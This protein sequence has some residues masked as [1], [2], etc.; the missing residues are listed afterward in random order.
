MSRH[1][2]ALAFAIIL[3]A[4]PLIG[5]YETFLLT[6]PIN[7]CQEHTCDATCD[8]VSR[9]PP[10]WGFFPDGGCLANVAFECELCKKTAPVADQFCQMQYWLSYELWSAK[11]MAFNFVSFIAGLVCLG[12]VLFYNGGIR[13]LRRR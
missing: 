7:T 3:L 4:F 9:C 11:L 12:Y 1:S 2:I 13:S 6:K 10:I 5:V 8:S